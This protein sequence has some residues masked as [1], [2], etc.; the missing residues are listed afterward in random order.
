[1]YSTE[2]CPHGPLGQLSWTQA[3]FDVVIPR[4][5]G[6]FPRGRRRGVVFIAYTV[7]VGC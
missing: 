1:M 7:A 5:T 3:S 4:G 6:L 2:V